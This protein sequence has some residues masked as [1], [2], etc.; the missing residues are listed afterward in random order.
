MKFWV[1]TPTLNQVLRL[2]ILKTILK[3][4]KKKKRI[5]NNNNNNPQQISKH[6]QQQVV[7]YQPGD[8]LKVKVKQ[9][10]YRPEQAQRVS[11]S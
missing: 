10:H 3:R 1:L 2:V 8:R 11:G 6:R 4:R 9:S 7:D 5:N